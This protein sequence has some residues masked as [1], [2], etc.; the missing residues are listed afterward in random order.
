MKCNKFRPMYGA[1]GC[2]SER[3]PSFKCHPRHGIS[4]FKVSSERL[5]KEQSLLSGLSFDVTK[6]REKFEPSTP[7]HEANALT[8]E[9]SRGHATS[10]NYGA[11]SVHKSV[12][13]IANIFYDSVVFIITLHHDFGPVFRRQKSLLPFWRREENHL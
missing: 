6:A 13:P 8:T 2:S 11:H 1:Q 12:L 9:F 5:A 7:G 4:V 3:S 10:A